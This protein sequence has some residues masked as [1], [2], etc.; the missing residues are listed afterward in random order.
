MSLRLEL[1]KNLKL[2]EP[3]YKPDNAGLSHQ[4]K[5]ERDEPDYRIKPNPAWTFETFKHGEYNRIAYFTA[6]RFANWDTTCRPTL[7]LAASGSGKT[8]LAHAIWQE[9]LKNRPQAN[10]VYV[11]AKAFMEHYRRMARG[12]GPSAEREK[13]RFWEKYREAD[14]FILDDVHR[15]CDEKKQL[16]E[17]TRCIARHPP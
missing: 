13:Q 14:L 1:D 8:H 11:H 5:Q 10:V 4:P 15:L 17:I 6:Q 3:E 2:P 9:A 7:V 16:D 12:E